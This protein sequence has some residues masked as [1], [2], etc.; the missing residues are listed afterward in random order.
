MQGVERA[1]AVAIPALQKHHN[2]DQGGS[3]CVAEAVA[4]SIVKKQRTSDRGD[5]SHAASC[6]TSTHIQDK[7][8]KN[9]FDFAQL[10]E[11]APIFVEACAGSAVLSSVAKEKGFSVVPID[12]EHRR[13][14]TKCRIVLLDLTSPF[15]QDILEKLIRDFH[16]LCVHVGL[17]SETC[18]PLSGIASSDRPGPQPLRNFD[19]P[20]G[21]PNLGGTTSDKVQKAN[22]LY[23]WA[24]RFVETLDK[25]GIYWTIES[26]SDSWLWELPE[27]SYALCN[28]ELFELHQCAFGA[29][30]KRPTSFLASDEVFGRLSKFCDGRH[31]HEEFVFDEAEVAYPRE[32]CL[33]YASVLETLYTRVGQEALTRARQARP[34]KQVR[35]R[36]Q[37]QLVSEYRAVQTVVFAEVPAVD[38]KNCL[39]YSQGPIP[40]GAKLLRA[41]ATRGKYL[42]V[43]GLFRDY[44]EFVT[45]ARQLWHPFDEL[46]HLPD[47][48]I[49]CIFRSLTG[50]LPD[51][52]KHRIN[53]I[54]AWTDQAVRLKDAERRLHESLHPNVRACLKGK[55]L[56]LLRY[57]ANSVGWPDCRLHD[58][59]ASGFFLT[60]YAPPTGVFKKEFKPAKIDKTKLLK[61]A[62][63]LK[64]ALL[65]KIHSHHCTEDDVE[66]YRITCEEA[67]EK[68]WLDGPHSPSDVS[69]MLGTENWL[70]V[71]RF[72]LR[73]KGK[74]RPIDDMKENRLNDAFA[75]GD[76][77]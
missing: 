30:C 75:S 41:E 67:D 69:K 39:V 47:D 50:S 9:S 13:Y 6:V 59:I 42:C 33:V 15:A 54:K 70:P 40:K 17:P 34:Y 52:T 8:F 38:H 71:R 46:V 23:A 36:A 29:T 11:G 55:R 19:F 43:F 58:E 48:L 35:G 68:A 16:V 18:F 77:N 20:H 63:F 73:Q 14:Q 24:G 62:K 56:E 12:C 25:R 66:L 37:P 74:L 57:L 4:A 3:N 5:L 7:G 45:A 49:R 27:M 1:E 26:P 21:V 53:T 32:L 2:L 31:L 60:G 28:G 76:K 44:Q 72:A 64:P 65:G 22:E 61:D 51:L 10:Q